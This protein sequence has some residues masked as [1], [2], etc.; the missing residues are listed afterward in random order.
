MKNPEYK[1]RD[2]ES[3]RS[4]DITY[5]MVNQWIDGLMKGWKEG[6]VEV[7]HIDILDGGM[8]KLGEN[9]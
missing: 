3:E 9:E 6:H 8:Q 2:E 4:M 5:W 1:W 7:R